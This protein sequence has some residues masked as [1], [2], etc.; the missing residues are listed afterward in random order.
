[1]NDNHEKKTAYIG[2]IAQ[3]YD[4]KRFSSEQGK[5]FAQLELN[6]LSKALR[7]VGPP[8]GKVIEVGC[9]TGRFSKYM[10]DNGYDVTGTDPSPDMVALSKQKYGNTDNLLF[11]EAWGDSLPYPD[12]SFDFAFTIRVLNQTSS[13]EDALKIVTEM[14]RVVKGGGYLLVEFV[15]GN[16]PVKKKSKNVRLTLR[17][18]SD[19]ESLRSLKR[20]RVG[21]VAV[22]SQ[23]LMNALPAPLIGLWRILE[24]MAAALLHPWASRR[25][26]LF[27]KEAEEA[28]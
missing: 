21:G 28:R 26:V 3:N 8:P 7:I 12:N 16:R 23:T 20:L 18:F 5:L 27:Y 15:N 22:F 6:Q 14:T 1:M 17:D 25:Y 19:H 2:G 10:A 13:R 11:L 4:Q 9:G 24:L